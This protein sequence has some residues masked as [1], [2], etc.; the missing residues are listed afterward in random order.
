MISIKEFYKATRGLLVLVGMLFM[1]SCSDKLT[2]DAK[3]PQ[4]QFA[5]NEIDN[6][7]TARGE[8]VSIL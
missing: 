7:L 1:L 3:S 4:M 8:R 5:A 2:F 6:A